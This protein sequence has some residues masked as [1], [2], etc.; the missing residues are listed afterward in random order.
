MSDINNDNSQLIF[1]L[2]GDK[3]QIA[4]NFGAFLPMQLPGTLQD[5]VNTIA[6]A[7]TS[8][9]G[10]SDAA[11]TATAQA[12]AAQASANNS[13]AS[14]AQA[15]TYATTATTQA[16]NASTSATNA[17]SSAS[18]AKSSEN[19]SK[20]S[21]NN[22]S[23]SAGAASQS[24]TAAAT[25][26]TN[27]ASS[28]T[29]AASSASAAAS[30]QTAAASSATAAASSQSAASNSATNAANSATAASG[31]ASTASTQATNSGNSATAAA[32]SA[33]N[34][35]TSATSASTSAGTATTQATN[36][37]NS[38]SAAATSASNAA[39][40]ATNAAAS[41]NSY[42]GLV[43]VP[44]TSSAMTLTT[45]Q[46][47]NGMII[48]TG[49]LTANTTITV[50]ATAHPFIAVN[51]TTGLYTLT[52]AMTGG[53]KT[54][55]V[56]QSKAGS[57]YCDGSTGVAG[58]SSSTSGLQFA[59]HTEV[60]A[61]TTLDLSYAGSIVFVKTAGVTITLPVAAAYQAGAGVAIVNY[62]GGAITVAVQG[63]DK[64]DLGTSLSL[65]VCDNMFFESTGAAAGSSSSGVNWKIA[66]YTNWFAPNVY[67]VNLLSG[68]IKFPDGTTQSTAN[69]TTAPTS[70]RYTPANT[71]T[72]IVTAGY[73]AGFVQVYQ[74]GVRLIPGD[75]FTATD[76]INVN[77]TVA[78]NGTD[79]YEVLTQVTYTPSMAIQPTSVQYTP[80]AGA[81]SITVSPYSVGYVDVYM[82]GA[83]LLTGVD[84]T[85]TDG[86]T[87]QFNN[88]TSAATDSFE[89]VTKTPVAVSGM[90]PLVG[91]TMSGNLGLS[92]GGLITGDFSNATYANRTYFQTST[93]NSTTSVA[94][95][96]NG[97]GTTAQIAAYSNS[98][99]AGAT[100]V[101][102][103]ARLGVTNASNVYLDTTSF[104]GASVLPLVLQTAGT[105]RLTIEPV[106]G[107]VGIN[108]TPSATSAPRFQVAGGVSAEGFDTGGAQLRILNT[109]ASGYSTMFR[110]DGSSLYLLHST[111]PYGSYN[112][113]RPLTL[114]HATG[115]LF[116]TTDGS[117][118]TTIGTTARLSA[119]TLSIA[120]AGAG[121]PLALR[122]SGSTGGS[123]WITGPDTSNSFVVY[124]QSGIGAFI[125]NGGTGWA[126]NS[127]ERLKNVRSQITGALDAVATLETVRY[128]WKA[129]DDYNTAYDLPDDSRVYVGCL[130]QEVQ[131]VL[132]E[133]VTTAPNGYLAVEYTALIPLALSAIKELKTANE[134][135]NQQ[136]A[137]MQAAI[138]AINKK[139]GS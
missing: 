67:G 117:A 30:S 6:D 133:A 81:S 91:G 57:L 51:N 13:A 8:V 130:A 64:T 135:L 25:S 75:D 24:Q 9:Q 59:K 136:I 45:A 16:S 10:A 55:T 19:N 35:A 83:R 58:A 114:E 99:P 63:S 108:K 31:S 61:N 32:T 41:A 112:T 56:P 109:S 113:S 76:G 22:A 128:T 47:G 126:A 71:A 44:V 68:S 94:A 38:A 139:L 36:A 43:T 84:Y 70:T 21:E 110:D 66:S 39:T 78:A 60:S 98:S 129:D 124:N 106:T 73:N 7:Q 74:N 77:L 14:A 26:A 107:A 42:N 96:P 15:Q 34:A 3:N 87:I 101:F 4:A 111:T 118:Y 50:P 115:N 85:A 88:F 123:Y 33:S 20:T 89:V 29:A 11:N 105:T 23:T 37:S 27:A 138:D 53:S 48:F 12:N 65:Y 2:D 62:S 93:A 122:N 90:L 120:S 72:K 92:S 86:A 137:S 97:T 125:G 80:G 134:T 132:P 17:A 131:A 121:A 104:G 54:V 49:A 116:L 95:I 119:A 28:A 82:N 52:F 127:D 69:S 103:M 40:S 100:P 79:Q 1:T 102:Q 5:M 46:F 18:A